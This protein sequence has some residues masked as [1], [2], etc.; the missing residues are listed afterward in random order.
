MLRPRAVLHALFHNHLLDTVYKE[1]PDLRCSSPAPW[2]RKIRVQ[3]TN[4]TLWRERRQIGGGLLTTP[5]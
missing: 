5:Q 2:Q 3:N 1:F 4:Q